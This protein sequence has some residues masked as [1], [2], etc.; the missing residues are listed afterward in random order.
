MFV[1]FASVSHGFERHSFMSWQVVSL[2]KYPVSQIQEEMLGLPE[3]EE[4]REG[5]LEQLFSIEDQVPFR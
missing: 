2:K 3:G 5:Q 4:E 1:Q